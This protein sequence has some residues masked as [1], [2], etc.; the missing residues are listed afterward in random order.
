MRMPRLGSLRASI[1]TVVV[2]ASSLAVGLFTVMVSYVNTMSSIDLLDKRLATLADVVGQN[3]TAALDFS[4][5]KAATEVLEALRR[6]PPVVSAC[7]YDV[8][9]RLFSEYQRDGELRLAL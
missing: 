4:D 2:L 1:I 9:G 6:E 5:R 3:S 7:L 8:R